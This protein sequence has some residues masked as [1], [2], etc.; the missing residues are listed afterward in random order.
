[1]QI[2]YN[3]TVFIAFMRNLVPLP[4]SEGRIFLHVCE[5]ALIRRNLQIMHVNAIRIVNKEIKRGLMQ[6]FKK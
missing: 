1:M 3:S 2:C 5:L 6:K 4:P